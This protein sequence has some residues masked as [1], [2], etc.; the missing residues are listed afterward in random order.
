[1]NL[2]F[3]IKSTEEGKSTYDQFMGSQNY[4]CK[5][6]S[7]TDRT[8]DGS[9][10]FDEKKKKLLSNSRLMIVTSERPGMGKTAYIEK[11]IKDQSAEHLQVLFSGD[12]SEQAFTERKKIIRNGLYCFDSKSFSSKPNVVLHI[13]IDMMDDMTE[14]VNILDSL[15]FE[16]C[17]F[18]CVSYQD[19][20]LFLDPIKQIFIEVQN[21]YRELFFSQLS[22]LS[23][24][25]E[26]VKS[27]DT[28]S[29]LTDFKKRLDEKRFTPSKL[30]S[31][32]LFHRSLQSQQLGQNT[33]QE[34]KAQADPKSLTLDKC[35]EDVCE[36][37]FDATSKSLKPQNCSLFQ[38]HNFINSLWFQVTEMDQV[39]LI[40][41]KITRESDRQ[42]QEKYKKDLE[43]YKK[44]Q[45]NGKPQ[46][47]PIPPIP[48]MPLVA[49]SRLITARHLIR[50]IR[51]LVWSSTNEIKEEMSMAM[52]IEDTCKANKGE[53]SDS[54]LKE[55]K[56]KIESLPK[57]DYSN[58]LAIFFNCGAMKV[59][60]GEV[61]RID[62]D[63]AL[64]IKSQ[65]QMDQPIPDYNKMTTSNR[66]IALLNE[67]VE[68]L[69][70]YRIQAEQPGQE[71]RIQ[72]EQPG[73]EFNLFKEIHQKVTKFN[74]KGYVITHDNYIKILMIY[75]KVLLNIPVVIMGATGCGKTFMITFI[76]SCLLK[77]ELICF[78]L[79]TGVTEQD[80]KL[81]LLNALTLATTTAAT[82]RVWVLFDEFNTSPLQCLISEIMLERKCSFSS[83]LG[84]KPFP[85]NIIFIA[86]C[87]PYRIDARSTNAGLEHTHS[88]SILSHRVYPIPE[89]L[90]SNVWDFGQLTR[91]VEREYI[92]CII[93]KDPRL[94][95]DG[96]N[97]RIISIISVSQRYLREKGN[98]NSVSLR[99]VARFSDL[100]IFFGKKFKDRETDSIVLSAYVCYFLRLEKKEQ[101]QELSKEI[102][103][104]SDERLDIPVRFKE[105]S[106]TF[107]GDLEKLGV[108]P[109]DVS[110]N[111]PLLEN[112]IAGYACL[113]TKIPAV[114]CGKP[115]T[116]KTL[117]V[118]ILVNAFGTSDE[119]KKQSLFFKGTPTIY[120]VYLWGSIGSTSS[121]IKEAF[122]RATDIADQN[123][124]LAITGTEAA[125]QQ[126]ASRQLVTIIFDEMGLAE[127]AP[128]N[129]L[130]VLHPLLEPAEKKIAFIGMSNWKL[131][132]SKM[133]RVVYVSRSE[134][135]EQD[136]FDTCQTGRIKSENFTKSDIESHMKCLCKSYILFRQ[137]ESASKDHHRNFHGSRDFYEMTKLVKRSIVLADELLAEKT[138]GH[139]ED[140]E[141]AVLN[142]IFINSIL[143][144]FS[145][146][147]INKQMT[148]LKMVE[149]F[150]KIA[151]PEHDEPIS[152]S[153]ID[154]IYQN[155]VDQ[156]SRHLMIFT[157]SS[158]VEE[159]IKQQVIDFEMNV[160]K[161]EKSKIEYLAPS[162]V[163][164]VTSVINRLPIF[165]KEGY[166]IIMKNFDEVY[167]CMYD[168]LNRNYYDEKQ[169]RQCQLQ[170]NND[171]QTVEVHRNFKVVVLM[172][173]QYSD[174]SAEDIEKKQP[175]PFLNR[176][177]KYLILD[178]EF[179]SEDRKE[180]VKELKQTY[181]DT[182][183]SQPIE[184]HLLVHNLSEELIFSS[185]IEDNS[186]IRKK[187]KLVDNTAVTLKDL[188]E[189]ILLTKSSRRGHQ[190]DE[191]RLPAHNGD[192]VL[193]K[194]IRLFS[195]NMI[196][197]HQI[198]PRLYNLPEDFERRFEE[199]HPYD[200]LKDYI[201]NLV[202]KPAGQRQGIVF[203]FSTPW[204]LQHL[205]DIYNKESSGERITIIKNSDLQLKQSSQRGSQIKELFLDTSPLIIEMSSMREWKH[206][207][208]L[209]YL[210][211]S[212]S[213][214]GQKTIIIVA[215]HIGGVADKKDLNYSSINYFTTDWEMIVIDALEGSHYKEY[216]EMWGKQC[217][218]I[219]DGSLKLFEQEDSESLTQ[220]L[221][222]SAFKNFLLR[223]I[224][225]Y[226]MLVRRNSAY[227]I[228][229][230]KT[231]IIK[232]FAV[233]IEQSKTS[234]LKIA[235][236]FD[237]KALKLL[238]EV[239][240]VSRV[241]RIKLMD[242]FIQ[243]M[244]EQIEALDGIVSFDLVGF[245]TL[246]HAHTFRDVLALTFERMVT[247]K[248]EGE[249]M[250]DFT[251]L[252]NIEY[253][254]LIGKQLDKKLTPELLT[255]LK[256]QI[257]ENGSD[258]L[259][260]GFL[261]SLKP[262]TLFECEENQKFDKPDENLL[263]AAVLVSRY[264]N[265][266]FKTLSSDTIIYLILEL[267]R[268]RMVDKFDFRT[269]TL[270]AIV[271]VHVF[272]EELGFIEMVNDSIEKTTLVELL[273]PSA[274]D[275]GFLTLQPLAQNLTQLTSFESRSDLVK[276]IKRLSCG[277]LLS[278]KSEANP[279][280][281]LGMIIVILTEVERECDN[282]EIMA[283]FKKIY[284]EYNRREYTT[285]ALS[286]LNGMIK[287][288]A[289]KSVEFLD[290]IF[291]TLSGYLLEL[292]LSVNPSLQ[293]MLFSVPLNLILKKSK[294]RI[295]Q[296]EFNLIVKLCQSLFEVNP[297]NDP[298][299]SLEEA[300]K[301][302]IGSNKPE[303]L[304]GICEELNFLLATTTHTRIP[305]I[306]QSETP[307]FD[308]LKHELNHIKKFIMRD[309]NYLVNK[310]DFI[311][312]K[313]V[314]QFITLCRARENRKILREE[315]QQLE[316]IIS[317]GLS[318][319]QQNQGQEDTRL[320]LAL[321]SIIFKVSPDILQIGSVGIKSM[322]ETLLQWSKDS[323]SEFFLPVDWQR[324][325]QDLRNSIVI[326]QPQALEINTFQRKLEVM[327][328]MFSIRVVEAAHLAELQRLMAR[329]PILF[330]FLQA[331]HQQQDN[332]I[333]AADLDLAFCCAAVAA[334]L[335]SLPGQ[336]PYNI[337][338]LSFD[339]FVP[340]LNF[341]SEQLA[342]VITVANL[343]RQPR[344]VTALYECSTPNCGY[345]TP[346]G[347]CGML[348]HYR[349]DS[350]MMNCPGCNVQ[351]GTMQGGRGANL[352]R[353]DIKTFINNVNHL[354]AIDDQVFREDKKFL[355]LENRERFDESWM[356]DKYSTEIDNKGKA[357]F[358]H[359]FQ[360]I[361]R[362]VA[363]VKKD[364]RLTLP[365]SA[366]DQDVKIANKSF[367][368]LRSLLNKD[369]PST[370]NFF[371]LVVCEL[372]R[373][374]TQ[375]M[376]N[377]QATRRIL[378]T[379]FHQRY[380][381]MDRLLGEYEERKRAVVQE[382]GKSS[383]VWYSVVTGNATRS[384]IEQTFGRG[385][386]RF[387]PMM[388]EA[389][390]IPMQEI[391]L[392]LETSKES[393]LKARFLYDLL[394]NRDLMAGGLR[395]VLTAARN[396]G[397]AIYRK[398]NLR[399]TE[400]DCHEKITMK[401]LIKGKNI[402]KLSFAF[403]KESKPKRNIFDSEDDQPA[404]SIDMDIEV[405]ESDKELHAAFEAFKEDWKTTKE[406][407]K[408]SGD[409]I[410]FKYEC[411]NL[412]QLK[413]LIIDLSKGDACIASY[414]VNDNSPKPQMEQIVMRSLIEALITIQ[415][416]W[417]ENYCSIIIPNA[418]RKQ[419]K[420]KPFYK[421][422][423]DCF[424]A[425]DSGLEEDL[426]RHT[427]LNFA[428][429]QHGDIEVNI[430]Y[431]AMKYATQMFARCHPVQSHTYFYFSDSQD[432]SLKRL[433]QRLR[434]PEQRASDELP[435]L[436]VQNDIKQVV[437]LE[438]VIKI[439]CSN[440][441]ESGSAFDT[442]NTLLKSIKVCDL[443]LVRRRI[444]LE[445]YK[446]RLTEW[447]VYQPDYKSTRTDPVPLY[448][449]IRTNMKNKENKS[450]IIE[451]LKIQFVDTFTSKDD[452][453]QDKLQSTLKDM[454]D[455]N[456]LD[457]LFE[458]IDNETEL[459][460]LHFRHLPALI[461][462]LES[463]QD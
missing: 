413:T 30:E 116:S 355:D 86:A 236:L 318:V 222:R 211:A 235:N 361:M 249:S 51:G 395:R 385:M 275:L 443:E 167:G 132:Q 73:E 389:R 34:L 93:D 422:P 278:P 239:G 145:G 337:Q 418:V 362:L 61:R 203:T 140:E 21:S 401:N 402:P 455:Y 157:Q 287:D 300:L 112:L 172:D 39:P 135:E 267:T 212:E 409:N 441:A 332:Q 444:Q 430:E 127:I 54:S 53:V 282:M 133:N 327:N 315:A 384:M 88:K 218:A 314:N 215:H 261:K 306:T 360:S 114:I 69:D 237:E 435:A 52:I 136:L 106:K 22:V 429:N 224:R 42:D 279:L 161:K 427:R 152:I 245:I 199:T 102:D 210:I 228:I 109:S 460:K 432:Q 24:Y 124:N 271:Y 397:T 280:T 18:N 164:T 179:I 290:R 115:G 381:A 251:S 265:R 394:Q 428:R 398:Y 231:S 357:I 143:R 323:K 253:I 349:S 150:Y 170:Y 219:F 2:A 434:L 247:S 372:A 336:S 4:F 49:A 94:E 406:Q 58:Q 204:Q 319:M 139:K 288:P 190:M 316:T 364:S 462:S 328:F 120:P 142:S 439:I 302:V 62:P 48:L 309:T 334:L 174:G 310:A 36:M 80:L 297:D 125:Q 342:K 463:E 153:S 408:K 344:A 421:S 298:F 438:T 168:L 407:L 141:A 37:F 217:K 321:M 320:L 445:K 230:D 303:N 207:Q 100:Y 77:D 166:T 325:V 97:K 449:N 415:S 424:I 12:P 347:D 43:E 410:K 81:M 350:S 188:L 27:L 403:R 181:L 366:D 270:F 411:E 129:P 195:R 154:L 259:I 324:E 175:A 19:G 234:Q 137:F 92:K 454:C 104:D 244:E 99:D 293:L 348:N 20:Y 123:K 84:D 399:F 243:K 113:L 119:K 11:A 283:S 370:M 442:A 64:L 41:P 90:I 382:A 158:I 72:A 326:G 369:L 46:S 308:Q 376:V 213:I 163:N 74:E 202:K 110:L 426:K 10:I 436:P 241:L 257:L 404:E 187:L 78:T 264:L 317:E 238:G 96:K 68:A 130:K 180:D 330:Q 396:I 386:S 5:C 75:Q 101:K 400:K 208:E 33:L 182:R 111:N 31:L 103:F 299:N 329:S 451:L 419:Q 313:V 322:H 87:N 29:S 1:M 423:D 353:I 268:S 138:L 25:S 383:L 291:G 285:F 250:E 448:D 171:K 83:E 47:P 98:D 273:V 289:P 176:F 343:C 301:Q 214:N 32:A 128:E 311:M 359:L 260:H 193:N 255:R 258:K 8:K 155:L 107:S 205:I 159:T 26:Q 71:F 9:K 380:S 294:L 417:I 433:V 197:V 248:L 63:V 352:R 45:D 346:V 457:E 38:F 15:L 160:R 225:T 85:Q 358:V 91:D 450:K 162:N 416:E 23:I 177:E 7:S 307:A 276:L 420:P 414:V 192:A 57:W 458:S 461:K 393:N 6:E 277:S 220:Q 185:V 198:N 148:S 341:P 365:L 456:E 266:K 295:C 263:A 367:S 206:I 375:Q 184:P 345:P 391:I 254:E 284:H 431:L 165:I 82:K 377:P 356:T 378:A 425:V 169:S 70:L 305:A 405:G 3:V 55:Y 223:D 65:L 227:D 131:D 13:K 76:S 95:G 50:L 16:V 108:V 374:H 226:N 240:D 60:Y 117:A 147:M 146:K 122:R 333:S 183:Q 17:F 89:S 446:D 194:I 453:T 151:K 35:F 312:I 272:E 189:Q 339:R 371:K 390:E 296:A 379:E 292:C 363:K 440:I 191:E 229:N 269:L 121:H 286:L 105:L 452:F 66:E 126:G 252:K 40:D 178:D 354:L 44:N 412:D 216:L 388:R 134:M 201:N 262:E 149:Q 28:F 459:A 338:Q 221:V 118:S 232:K 340:L 335:E 196:L 14:S 246:I 209:R 387:F 186:A 67:L 200:S 242:N 173:R 437:Q 56:S 373:S 233:M 59:I 351:V 144:A 256:R 281:G 331:C 447:E 156:H 79:H 304:A 274:K 368:A 392:Y